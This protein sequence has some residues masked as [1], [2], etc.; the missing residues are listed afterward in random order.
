MAKRN[1]SSKCPHPRHSDSRQ[2]SQFDKRSR[3][4]Q[5]IVERKKEQVHLLEVCALGGATSATEGGFQSEL[6][7]DGFCPTG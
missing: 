1:Q 6:P 4:D 2:G 5:P 7:G 3:L